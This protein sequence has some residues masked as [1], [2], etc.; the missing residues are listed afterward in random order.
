MRSSATGLFEVV[1]FVLGGLLLFMAV[2][3]T[4]GSGIGES[5]Y[6]FLFSFLAFAMY[7]FRRRMRI[8]RK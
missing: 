8:K 6:Y 5:W 3:V 4:T 7:F 1:W 2:D